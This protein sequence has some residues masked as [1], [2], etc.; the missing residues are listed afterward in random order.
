[1]IYLI[2]GKF[3]IIIII[4]IIITVLFI[5]MTKHQHGS[6]GISNQLLLLMLPCNTVKTL[7]RNTDECVPFFDYYNATTKFCMIISTH[8]HIRNTADYFFLEP[9][10]VLFFLEG[11][12]VIVFCFCF[13]SLR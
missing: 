1:M 2:E 5:L 8:T 12:F 4:I 9:G 6:L 7:Q 3:I 11:M 13:C 10:C